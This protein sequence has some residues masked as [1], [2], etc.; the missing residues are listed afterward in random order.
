[1]AQAKKPPKT[2]HFHKEWEEDYFFVEFKGKPICLICKDSV[3]LSK[4]CNLER[5]YK[6]KHVITKDKYDER[7]PPKTA[8]RRAQLQKL[9]VAY[10]EQKATFTRP[11]T[12]AQAATVA[13]YRVSHVM[14]KNKKSFKDGEFVKEAITA[15]AESLFGGFE[16]KREIMSAIKDMQLSRSTVTRRCEDMSEDLHSQLKKDVNSCECFSL[17]FD[18]STDMVDVAQLCIY[19]RMV[20]DDMTAKE[21]L[22]TILP[23]KGTTRGED[24]FHAFM[25]FVN[26]HQNLTSELKYFMFGVKV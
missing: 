24:I 3:A 2:Y 15:A 22:L 20:F 14:A 19:I 21:E 1:M 11:V 25:E 7:F 17:Q 18:E 5:H 23:L 13:S 26:R 4:K 16:N 9:K 12:K 8:L 10:G 6:Q